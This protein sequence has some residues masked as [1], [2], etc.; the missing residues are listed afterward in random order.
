MRVAQVGCAPSGH[1]SG[2]LLARPARRLALLAMDTRNP[3]LHA[4]STDQT[5]AHAGMHDHPGLT[6]TAE[7]V[8]V[9]VSATGLAYHG[10]KTRKP[11][12]ASWSAIGAHHASVP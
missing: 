10:T 6:A 11:R 3:L 12:L 8:Y 1:L 7:A 5:C 4:V 9:S 2:G